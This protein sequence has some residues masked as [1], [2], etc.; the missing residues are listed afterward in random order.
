M[1]IFLFALLQVGKVQFKKEL[2]PKIVE[3]IV[4]RAHSHFK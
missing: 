2:E 3:K 1:K 4:K